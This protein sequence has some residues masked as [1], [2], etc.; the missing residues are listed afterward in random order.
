MAIKGDIEISR[1]ITIKNKKN[2]FIAIKLELSCSHHLRQRDKFIQI[3][4]YSEI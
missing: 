2:I 3:V 1:N 4:E